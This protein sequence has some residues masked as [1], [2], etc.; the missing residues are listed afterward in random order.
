MIIKSIVLFGVLGCLVFLLSARIG[1]LPSQGAFLNPLTGFWC[2]A[3]PVKP[4][5]SDS[6]RVRGIMND[7]VVRYD[8]DLIPHIFG[9][10]DHDLYFAQGYATAKARLWQMDWLM[11]IAAGRLSEIVR[12]GE[13]HDI[14]YRRIGIKR[15]AERS[16]EAA[17]ADPSTRTMLEAYSDGVNAFIGQLSPKDY[18]IEFKLMNYKPEKWQPLYSLLILKMMGETMS[19]GEP[20]FAMTNALIKFGKD[21]T[22]DLYGPASAIRKETVLGSN[23]WA[24][25]GRRTANGFPLLANDPH[26][27]ITLPSI[28]YQVQLTSP[29]ENVEGVSIPGIPCVIIGFN[30]QIAWGQTNAAI[31]VVDWIHLT[32]KGHLN[33]EYW[34]GTGWRKTERVVE[35][36]KLKD[37]RVISDTIIYTDFGPVVYDGG[38]HQVGSFSRQLHEEEGF[39]MRWTLHQP[40]NDL[41]G[42]YLLNRAQ[43]YDD[44]RMALT[45]ICCPTQNFAFADKQ[46]DIAL[47]TAGAIPIRMSRQH[48]FVLECD[49]AR[50]EWTG[51]IAGSRL[52]SLK[53]PVSGLLYSA[54]EPIGEASGPYIIDGHFANPARSVRIN[55]RLGYMTHA[56]V[57]SMRL[58]QNDAYSEIAKVVLP[59][60][61]RRLDA[62]AC[63]SHANIVKMLQEWDLRFHASSA[64]AVVFQEWWHQLYSALWEDDIDGVS[65]RIPWPDESKTISILVSDTNSHWI[66]NIR[67]TQRETMQSLVNTS[68]LK[69]IAVLQQRFGS[70]P[71]KWNWD[72]ARNTVIRHLGGMDAFSSIIRNSDGAP[73][74]INALSD[75]SGPSWRMVVELGP[76]IVGYGILPGG[77]S[78]NPGSYYYD[79]NLPLW[80]EGKLKPL[81]FMHNESEHRENILMTLTLKK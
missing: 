64:A 50:R 42:F 51:F 16:L 9:G 10:D 58:L 78:G 37:S 18:P 67:T 30:Q 36:Y 62:N 1:S 80:E 72:N 63:A 21:T 22:E 77:E 28:W 8:E 19:G 59:V 61:L 55:E 43:N 17:L 12:D 11:H 44:Y 29:A 31:D 25:D 75:N 69:T 68:F 32:F 79:D 6:R 34:D 24:L 71:D 13:R 2:N 26:L 49:S 4:A 23:N 35:T 53:N 27:G 70:Q 57:D 15:A 76:S 20:Q 54:N 60:L 56:T 3:E 40:S 66:D 46:G 38:R 5:I 45:N 48:Q 81:L 74:T 41:K 14:F 52:P 33:D 39:A 47:T 73:N 65:V 7:V